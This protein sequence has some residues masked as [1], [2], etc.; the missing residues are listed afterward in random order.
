MDRALEYE[1]CLRAAVV[2]VFSFIILALALGGGLVVAFE[3][4]VA[5]SGSRPLTTISNRI[6][7]ESLAAVWVASPLIFAINYQLLAKNLADNFASKLS[8]QF[9]KIVLASYICLF[10]GSATFLLAGPLL[11]LALLPLSAGLLAAT[12]WSCAPA[13][14]FFKKENVQK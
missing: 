2:F 4:F 8:G 9:S 3:V 7:L 6:A 13:H 1:A 5:G 11:V 12:I 14:H 10:A